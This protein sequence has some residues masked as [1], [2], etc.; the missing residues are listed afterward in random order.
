M[1]AEIRS[2]RVRANGLDFHV[3]A[4]GE[5]DRLALCLHGFP[6]LGRSWRHQLPLLAKLGYRAWAPDLRGYG[7]S[8][9][10]RGLRSYAIEKLQEDVA[11][12]IDAAAP[13]ETVLVAH[14]WGALIAWQFAAHAV[15]PLDRLVILNGPPPGVPKR[16]S[17]RQIGRYLYVIFF[18]IPRLPEW[19]FAR[20]DYE[21]IAFA[22]RRVAGKPERLDDEDLR[23]FR[24]AAAQPGA[25][26]AMIDYYRALVRGGGS[27]RM[28][29]RGF[30]TIETPTLMIWGDADPVL[31]PSMTDDADQWVKDVTRRFLPG[32]GHWVQQ[33]APDDVNEILSAWLT[34]APV[35]GSPRWDPSAEP[36]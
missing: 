32:I 3:N 16:P 35:P 6:E 28:A 12:L 1:S 31:V 30:P 4:A 5:G 11:G 29:A 22:F 34:D 26:T 7:K 24:E 36:R 20:R 23:H 19:L 14:D 25:M 13:R 18:Q 15:R 2:E 8:D 21:P 33:E 10:P 27:R 17:L 9:R